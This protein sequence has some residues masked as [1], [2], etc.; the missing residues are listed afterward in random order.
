MVLIFSFVETTFTIITVTA[1][2]K[3][4]SC[5]EIRLLMSFVYQQESER[6]FLMFKMKIT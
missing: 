4:I 6:N 2:M 3:T 5:P 1:K